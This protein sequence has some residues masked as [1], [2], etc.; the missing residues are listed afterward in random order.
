MIPMKPL[1]AIQ[2]QI[3]NKDES[4]ANPGLIQAN[5]RRRIASRVNE[6]YLNDGITIDAE[7]SKYT[8]DIRETDRVVIDEQHTS[9]QEVSQ[10]SIRWDYSRNDALWSVQMAVERI[11]NIVE[12]SLKMDHKGERKRKLRLPNIITEL[13]K[14]YRCS[15]NGHTI[16]YIP[17]PIDLHNFD[18]FL[19][20]TLL[21]P[22]R[23][24]PVVVISK[25]RST[26]TSLIDPNTI[27]MQL[28]GLAQIVEIGST[29]VESRFLDELGML[30]CYN[31]AVRVYQPGFELQ[32]N[33]NEHRVFTQWEIQRLGKD[34]V[35]SHL[36]KLTAASSVVRGLRES[37]TSRDVRD[38]IRKDRERV[39]AK[40]REDLRS[41]LDDNDVLRKL[42]DTAD[43]ELREKATEIANLNDKV[44]DLQDQLF[45]ARNKIAGL[46]ASLEAKHQIER[47]QDEEQEFEES[48]NEAA[49]SVYG[50]VLEA[51]R[52]F[53]VHLVFHNK[54]KR[55]AS[56]SDYWYPQ[57][58]L[59]AFQAMSEICEMRNVAQKSGTNLGSL[60]S[61]FEE[62]GI[63]YSPHISEKTDNLW[64]REYTVK[65]K[66]RVQKAHHH[67]KLG[68]DRDPRACLRIHFFL[69]DELG[70]FVVT[71]VGRHKTNTLT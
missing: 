28:A 53:S 33:P 42:L 57:K 58:V 49:N 14:E 70:K 37:R 39:L 6:Y 27:A 18:T 43:L 2:F 61:L 26:N 69:D 10:W 5:I 12:F 62:R 66:D 46:L 47:T 48:F 38:A 50:V 24:I 1:Y 51:E 19:S 22:T 21:S 54:A 9:D 45:D 15:I 30:A 20:E 17:V 4:V 11:D 44:S 64:R 29:V 65:Y 71:H 52:R 3:R 8:I 55:S 56:K 40:Y 34:D 63:K 7:I 25:D 32:A 41:N 36:F 67:I 13:L 35:L 59:D 60:E 31:G 16:S 68:S 23:T